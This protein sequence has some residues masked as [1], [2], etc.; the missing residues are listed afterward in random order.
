MTSEGHGVSHFKRPGRKGTAG[1]QQ[2]KG[3]AN[4]TMFVNVWNFPSIS[5]VLFCTKVVHPSCDPLSAKHLLR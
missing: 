1:L 2:P 3:L 5:V 4:F